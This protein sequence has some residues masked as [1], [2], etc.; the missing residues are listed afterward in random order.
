MCDYEIKQWVKNAFPFLFDRYVE[1]RTKQ[2]YEKRVKLCHE[3][4]E[5]LVR[6]VFDK[7]VQPKQELNLDAPV[8]FHEKLNWLKLNW[9]D[10]RAIICSDKYRVREYVKAKGLSF[11]LNELYAVYDS[12]EE[13]DLSKLPEKFILKATHDSGH[14][15]ICNGKEGLNLALAKRQLNWWLEI[16]YAYMSGEWPYHTQHPRIICEKL[17]EEN[18][19]GEI[20]DYKL[21]CFNGEPYVFFFASD[22]KHH[23]K[24]DFYDLHWHKQ[25]YRWFYEPSGK[26]FAKPKC[27]QEMIEY[28]KIL[29]EGFPF[30]RVDFYEVEGTVYF[31]ELTFFHGGGDGWF[32]PKEMDKVFGDLI[33]LPEKMN[34]WSII[35]NEKTK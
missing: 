26:V 16:D 25:A 34:P 15:V 30:V 12:V 4:P 13:I 5:K 32:E 14:N 35:Q 27:L 7:I 22:R 9:F 28:A 3:S 31:G 29:S 18:S 17:L 33:T 19:I 24:A 1:F 2:A 10:E 6:Y 21:F 20:V 8:T 11:L 23:A